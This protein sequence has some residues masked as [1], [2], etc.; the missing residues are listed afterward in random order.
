MFL[1]TNIAAVNF[2]ID[3]YY[4]Q[5]P[6]FFETLSKEELAYVTKHMRRLEFRKKQVIF[7]EDSF[8]KGLYIIRKG[9]VKMY[10]TNPDGKESIIGI[11]RK[12][13]HIGYR[14]LLAN[15][16]NSVSAAAIDN[17]VLSFLPNTVFKEVLDKSS[18]LAYV[19]LF[20]LS[21]EFSV[22]INRT[23]AFS[24]YTV[25]ERVALTLLILSKIYAN[26]DKAI[27]IS[28][29]R[30]DFAGFVGTAKETLVRMLRVFKDEK[31]ISTRGTKI[32][33]LKPRALERM[34]EKRD[35]PGQRE[36]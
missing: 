11:Y 20:H 4:L 9:K 30:D 8:A 26:G 6:S 29:N 19:L 13:D 2:D 7:H 32:I 27:I 31:I 14:S 16:H 35:H 24:Y 36:E 28:L 34:V 15:G 23:T 10:K 22:W 18:R 3:H 25:K 5:S 1:C 17:V 21:K 12:G 33:V